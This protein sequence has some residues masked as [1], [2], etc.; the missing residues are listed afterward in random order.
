MRAE[1]HKNRNES[2][3]PTGRAGLL[4][5]EARDRVDTIRVGLRLY[6]GDWLVLA[7]QASGTVGGEPYEGRHAIFMQA[8]DGRIVEYREYFGD[9]I[10]FTLPT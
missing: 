1:A 3:E 6:D 10:H 8:R 9:L 4:R 2:P 7:D 5:H